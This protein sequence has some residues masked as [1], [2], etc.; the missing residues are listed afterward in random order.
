MITLPQPPHH[1]TTS[2]SKCFHV[3]SLTRAFGLFFFLTIWHTTDVFVKSRKTKQN[4]PP[5]LHESFDLIITQN[6]ARANLRLNVNT[7]YI[8]YTFQKSRKS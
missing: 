2:F 5:Y 8:K 4:N 6:K 3:S 1:P 7:L